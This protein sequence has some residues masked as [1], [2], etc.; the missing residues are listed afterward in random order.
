VKRVLM[1]VWTGV[2][3]DTRVLRE[4]GALVDAGHQV[5]IVGRSVPPGFQPP[6]RITVESAGRAPLAQGRTRRLSLPERAAR[7]LLL[8]NHV[9]RRVRGWAREAGALARR[10]AHEHGRPDVV[11]VHDF[12]ALEVGAEL[13]AEWGVP[14]IYDTHE[15][16]RGRPREG[17]PAPLRSRRERRTETSLAA[18]AAAILTVGDGVADALRR[19]NPNWPEITVVRNTFPERE[20]SAQPEGTVQSPPSAAVYTGRLARD[21]ELETIAA[22]SMLTSLPIVVMGPG[23]DAWLA[24][25]DARR[26]QVRPAGTIEEVDEVLASAGIALVTHSDRWANHRLAM[27]NKLFHALS[28]GVPVVATDVGELAAVVRAYD[29]GVL[30]PPSDAAALAAAV[31]EVSRRH[32]HFCERARAARADATWEKDRTALIAVY[33]GM[34]PRPARPG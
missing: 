23:D 33:A 19:D 24:D 17:R 22:A 6:E 3:T 8:P 25:Y 13:A 30:Y 10:W 14:F 7:W 20:R 4:A 1:L 5:H 11:H 16:W 32:E 26:V 2:A 21:R 9:D 29:C 28:L 27:P 31:E 34:S 12:T 18:Q 15:Y